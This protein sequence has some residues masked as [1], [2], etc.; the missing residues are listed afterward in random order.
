L[1]H[2]LEAHYS[3]KLEQTLTID[4]DEQTLQ[5]FLAANNV[6]QVSGQASIMI[7]LFF[8]EAGGGAAGCQALP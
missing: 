1:F 8:L 7:D 2:C 6:I 5:H 4:S 3:S